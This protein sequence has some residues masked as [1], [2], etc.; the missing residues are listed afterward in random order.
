MIAGALQSG[1][2][3]N[4]IHKETMFKVD[5]FPL[6]NRPFDLSKLERRLAYELASELTRKAYIASPEDNILSK[7]EWY[8][9]G[10][11][12]SDRQ[13]ND[14]LNVLKVQGAN[15]DTAYLEKWAQK[16]G[17][18]DLLVQALDIIK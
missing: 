3:F 5:I 4:M 7:L 12:I 13:W 1:V 16:L 6:K 18:F 9:L 14:V 2:S 8:R 11:E 15:I 10:G 17:L